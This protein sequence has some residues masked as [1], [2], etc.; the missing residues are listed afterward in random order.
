MTTTDKPLAEQTPAEIDTALEALYL[1]ALRLEQDVATALVNVHYQLGEKKQHYSRNRYT[2][3][4]THEQAVAALTERAAGHSCEFY[5]SDCPTRP[6]ARYTQAAQALDDNLAA[7]APL[8]AEYRTRP[9]SR[10]FL[11]L[12][13]GG[14]IHQ[15]MHC[16]TCN[17]GQSRTEFGWQPRLSGLTED[18]AVAQLGEYASSLCTVCFPSAP[19]ERTDG[20]LRLAAKP[21]ACPGSGRSEVPGTW[22]RQGM[23]AYGRCQ[24]CKTNQTVTSRGAIRKHAP[25]K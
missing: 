22:K 20:R 18:E 11:C 24:E 9:W 12:A 19:A 10:F 25:A 23:S 16:S 21:P 6:L 1:A 15:S 8:H 13:N 17:R 3:P 5:H 4:T 7:Q 2:W 14:H